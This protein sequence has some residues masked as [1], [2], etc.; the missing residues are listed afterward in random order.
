MTWLGFNHEQCII[1]DCFASSA[2]N[3]FVQGIAATAKRSPADLK[4]AKTLRFDGVQAGGEWL[5]LLHQERRIGKN[6]FAVTSTQ[7]PANRLSGDLSQDVPERNVDSA[8]CVSDASAASHPECV[9]VRFLA[10]A[11][12]LQR[13]LSN[14]KRFQNTQG[15]FHQNVVGKGRTPSGNTFI[16]VNGD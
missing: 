9:R 13:I 3:L 10:H 12:R 4:G 1:P 11:L 5:R 16:C 15:P 2:N 14:K 8:D 6:P 7:E